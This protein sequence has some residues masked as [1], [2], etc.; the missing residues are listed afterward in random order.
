MFNT[1]TPS[2]GTA[3]TLCALLLFAAQAPAQ[4]PSP[5]LPEKLGTI[6]FPISCNAA[7]QVQMT[8]GV[9]LYHSFHWPEARVSVFCWSTRDLLDPDFAEAWESRLRAHP[10]ADFSFD[11]HYLEWESRHGRHA[12]AVLVCEVGRRGAF[13]LREVRGHFECGWPW[14]WQAIACDAPA[15]TAAALTSAQSHWL[16]RHAVEIVKGRQLIWFEPCGSNKGLAFHAGGTSLRRIDI[17][18]EALLRSIDSSKR[19]V[20]RRASKLGYEVVEGG[21]SEQRRALAGVAKLTKWTPCR[22]GRLLVS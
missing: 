22:A 19:S 7:A 10:R 1:P 11:L 3:A 16:H 17:G 21:S 5:G 4:G 9:A 14:R 18:D 12:I 13:V 15:P 8:R 2:A 20:L 6:D